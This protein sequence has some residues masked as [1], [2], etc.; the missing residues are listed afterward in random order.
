MTKSIIDKVPTGSKWKQILLLIYEKSPHQ[1]LQSNFIGYND[2]NH[3]IAK[4]LKI[5]GQEL[6][7]GI[8]FL[9]DNKL[10]KETNIDALNLIDKNWS[11]ALLLTDK[12]FDLAIKLENQ[13]FSI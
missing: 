2:D 8:S 4:K 9:R 13:L 6:I 10:V 1:Y 12:G 3:P 7:L 11:S 5:S